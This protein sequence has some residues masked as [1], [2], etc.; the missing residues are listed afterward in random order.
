MRTLMR[1][2][3]ISGCSATPAVVNDLIDGY[4]GTGASIAG[5]IGGG[6]PT[7]AVT[8]CGTD[9]QISHGG[10][11]AE[12]PRGR[13][14]FQNGAAALLLGHYAFG[15]VLNYEFA[16]IDVTKFEFGAL[17]RKALHDMG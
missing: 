12:F 13:K 15:G 4:C 8:T 2:D 5:R 7:D 9:G 11:G 16:N 14:L 6:S 17:A 1:T 10:S 3:L